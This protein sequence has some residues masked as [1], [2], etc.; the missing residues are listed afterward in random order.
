MYICTFK[1]KSLIYMA[2]QLLL[3]RADAIITTIIVHVVVTDPSGIA[4]LYKTKWP[5][6]IKPQ[7]PG[8]SRAF[9]RSRKRCSG[10]GAAWLVPYY[11]A[12]SSGAS[13]VGSVPTRRHST[14]PRT[15]SHCKHSRDRRV[16]R[17]SL[18]YE[19]K[20][21][22]NMNVCMKVVLWT[23][24]L[25]RL[26]GLQGAMTK[27]KITRSSALYHSAKVSPFTRL[28]LFCIFIN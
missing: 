26:I 3:D 8:R 4:W 12:A 20:R 11:A 19:L 10:A 21:I 6:K 14:L 17:I 13:V 9:R 28:L 16:R 24:F 1:T 7:N 15:I 25:W 5:L 18:P 27:A 22:V 2:R 23:V